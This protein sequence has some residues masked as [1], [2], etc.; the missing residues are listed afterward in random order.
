LSA[1]LWDTAAGTDALAVEEAEE[2]DDDMD[3]EDAV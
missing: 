2:A 1:A 3:D